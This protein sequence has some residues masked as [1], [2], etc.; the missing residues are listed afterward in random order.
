[1]RAVLYMAHPLSGEAA[2]S[3]NIKR[4]L[5]WLSWLRSSFPRTTFI[6][7]WIASVMSVG[8]DGTVA[9]REAGLVDDCAVVERCDGVVLVGGR[10]SSGMMRESASAKWTS[11]LTWLGDEPPKDCTPELRATMPFDS[12][13]A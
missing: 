9:E 8:G 3:I 13:V 5:R 7:P 1:M 6:A 2:P 4:A 12:E 11:D 10:I